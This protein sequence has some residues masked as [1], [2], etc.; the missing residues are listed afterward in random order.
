[1][2]IVLG[3]RL[4]GF[5]G[6][7][8]HDLRFRKADVSELGLKLSQMSSRGRV[9]DDRLLVSDSLH[10]ADAVAESLQATTSL[11]RAEVHE[12]LGTLGIRHDAG[13]AVIPDESRTTFGSSRGA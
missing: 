5:N 2:A 6:F 3:Q 8:E 1:M 13:L 7:A 11:R 4:C 12:Q 10:L 9:D